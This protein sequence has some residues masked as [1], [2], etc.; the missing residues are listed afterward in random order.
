MDDLFKKKEAPVEGQPAIDPMVLSNQSRRMRIVEERVLNLNKKV[1]VVEENILVFEKETR[2][3][4][5]ELSKNLGEMKNE[6]LKMRDRFSKISTEVEKKA[7]ESEFLVFKK[8]L[9]MWKPVTF[10]SRME[11]EEIVK[12]H[13]N[14]KDDL[15]QE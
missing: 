8:Y 11:V 5:N 7:S 15:I 6:F 2:L 12:E 9:E 1:D 13:L 3:Q 10:V 14:K 4:I